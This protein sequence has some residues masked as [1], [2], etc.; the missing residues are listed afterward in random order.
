MTCRADSLASRDSPAQSYSVRSSLPISAGLGSSAAY[1][2]AVA[3]SLLYTHG[4]LPASSQ[5]ADISREHAD[6]VNAWAFLAEKVIHGTPSGVDNTVATLGGAIAFRKA[7]KGRD[8]SLDTINGYAL[9]RDLRRQ[10]TQESDKVIRERQV[11]GSQLF[12]H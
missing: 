9:L 4:I 8:G 3:S 2:V 5:A 6:V 12:A 11:Q 1:S 7:V 10:S